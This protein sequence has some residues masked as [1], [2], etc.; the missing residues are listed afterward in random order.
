MCT[1]LAAGVFS[2]LRLRKEPD[3][4]A[5][6][7]RCIAFVGSAAFFGFVFSWLLYC[8][9]SQIFYLRQAGIT[10]VFR[11]WE[12]SMS[13]TG[14]LLSIALGGFL[15]IRQDSHSWESAVLAAVILIACARLAETF[16]ALSRAMDVDRECLM[17]IADPYGFGN[18]LNVMVHRVVCGPGHRCGASSLHAL[19]LRL[20]PRCLVYHFFPDRILHCTDPDGKPSCGPA[21]DLGISQKSAAVSLPAGICLPAAVCAAPQPDY[22]DGGFLPGAGQSCFL[23]RKNA[24]PAARLPYG[25]T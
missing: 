13:M 11:W 1:F 12:G 22:T 14:A 17:T 20:S 23:A 21:Y 9:T 3:K 5:A 19:Q 15:N 8:L 7:S 4:S 6:F 16:G 25:C 2:L 24:E 18:V 10:A